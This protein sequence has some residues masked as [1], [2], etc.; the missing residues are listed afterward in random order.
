MPVDYRLRMPEGDCIHYVDEPE[1]AVVISRLPRELTARVRA[2]HFSH[3]SRGVR[4]LGSTTRGGHDIVLCALPP[5][6]SLTRFLIPPETAAMYGAVHG[7]QWPPLAVRRFMLYDVLLHEIGHLQS[8]GD[9]PGSDRRAFARETRAQEFAEHW[10]EELW[11]QPF[12][13]DDP[14]HHP[15]SPEEVAS[16]GQ[17]GASEAAYKLGRQATEKKSARPH[18]E[19]AVELYPWHA[20]ALTELARCLVFQDDRGDELNTAAAE[21]L[22]RALRVHPTWWEANAKLALVS[23][24]LGLYEDARS[25]VA[26]ASRHARFAPSALSAFADAHADWGFLAESER[27]FEKALRVR[28]GH[29][30]TLCD[31]ARAIWDLAPHTPEN[32]ARAL[33]LFE[34]ALAADAESSRTHFYVASALASIPGEAERALRHAEQ[35]VALSPRYEYERAVGLVTR[36]RQPLHSGETAHTEREKLPIRAYDRKTGAVLED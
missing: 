11:S 4:R 22:R 14:V 9:R 28:P 35:S 23:G 21:L 20:L 17:W 27:L 31:Y 36:L 19:R 33:G 25:L 8:V 5:H 18:F 32:T 16:L 3:S 15:P 7:M 30:R 12:A 34:R 2:V 26:R 10:R 24:H 1:V 29:A 13:H 6:V